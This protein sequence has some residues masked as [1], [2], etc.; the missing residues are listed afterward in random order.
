MKAP[1]M[2]MVNMN[3]RYIMSR[4]MGIPMARSSTT[5]SIRSV[6]SRLASPVALTASRAIRLAKP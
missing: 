4:K 5:R 6:R 2:L 3:I 1:P